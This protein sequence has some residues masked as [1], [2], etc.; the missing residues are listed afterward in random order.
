M[1]KQE[2]IEPIGSFFFAT[3]GDP[4]EGGSQATAHFA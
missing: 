3:A 4:G 2:K 1:T